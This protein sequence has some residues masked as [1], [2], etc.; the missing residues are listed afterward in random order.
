M[1]RWALIAAAVSGAL[2]VILG[3]FGAHALAERLDAS[4]EALWRTASHYHFLH[5]LILA[6]A[7]LLPALGIGRRLAATACVL[8]LCGI[9]VFSGSLYGLALSGVGVLGA[10]TPIG[11]VVL[12]AG[13]IVLAV[14]AF[15]AP[16]SG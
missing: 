13:W 12:I 14:A 4:G 6:V 16:A 2:A 8:W 7:A 3:A 1:L 10:I 9:A 5:T 11:G 15:R